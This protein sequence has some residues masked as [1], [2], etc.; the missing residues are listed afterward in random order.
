MGVGSRL[1][2]DRTDRKLALDFMERRLAALLPLPLRAPPRARL[3]GESHSGNGP[4][5]AGRAEPGCTAFADVLEEDEA[6][7]EGDP[8]SHLKVKKPPRPLAFFFGGGDMHEP[9]SRS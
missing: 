1:P 6:E 9:G 4:E 8:K 5:I 2:H 7:S 3:G